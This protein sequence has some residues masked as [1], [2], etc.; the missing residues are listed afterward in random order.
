M[1][2]YQQLS[3]RNQ[4]RIDRAY[5]TFAANQPCI[6]SQMSP[7]HLH[8]YRSQ[9]FNQFGFPV[10]MG[11]RPPDI[12]ILPL[13]PTLHNQ[14]KASIHALGNERF[15]AMH[16]VNLDQCLGQLHDLFWQRIRTISALKS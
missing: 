12:L 3:K 7:V 9:K 6:V 2:K 5:R 8:H 10:G 16:G 11:L 14:G 13:A 4:R 15:E 1:I